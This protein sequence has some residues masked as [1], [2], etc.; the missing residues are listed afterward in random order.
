ML[1][2]KHCVAVM[3]SRIR[4]GGWLLFLILLWIIN[5]WFPFPSFFSAFWQ[6]HVQCDNYDTTMW[7]G[8]SA[9]LSTKNPWWFA[10][11]SVLV[12]VCW[13]NWGRTKPAGTRSYDGCVLQLP[14]NFKWI[15]QLISIYYHRWPKQRR[16]FNT[17]R[18]RAACT[19]TLPPG[20]ACWPRMKHSKL[21][22][23]DWPSMRRRHKWT[24]SGKFRS[25][26]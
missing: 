13:I 6:R 4:R 7:S 25:N 5:N 9:W 24:T 18:Q 12:A 1:Q 2:S 16:A 8:S 20:T 10:W 19:G 22:I 11:S 3:Q 15:S 21:P 23:L 14:F 17:S 26:G